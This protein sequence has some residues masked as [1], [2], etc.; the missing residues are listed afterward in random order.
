VHLALGEQ[1]RE[2]NLKSQLICNRQ[3]QGINKAKKG[4]HAR[5]RERERV[6]E[7]VREKRNTYAAAKTLL[8]IHLLTAEVEIV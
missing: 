7:R 6:R 2:I 4:C 8:F 5:E 1:R 3:K